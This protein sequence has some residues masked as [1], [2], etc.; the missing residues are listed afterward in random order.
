[1]KRFF[2][3]ILV[4]FPATWLFAELKQAKVERPTAP[5]FVGWVDDEIVVKFD[6]AT[7]A[8][9]DKSALVRGRFGVADFDALAE[10]Y[11]SVNVTEKFP[12]ARAKRYMGR[13]VD[14]RGWT[15]I[16]FSGAVDLDA[17]I[18]D[19][20]A[21]AGVLDAQKIGIHAVYATPNDGNYSS[22]WHLN[23]SNDVDVD[24]PEAWNIQ[25]G[26]S[27]IIVG[28]LDT[29]VRYFHKDLGG[30]NASY[31]TP[32]AV[33]GNMW[34][35]WA[36][37]NGI[38]GV[39]DDGN[40]Y[41][42]DWVGWDWVTGVTGWSGEDVS[43]PDNDPRDFN[44]H[45]THCAGNIAAINNNG[46]ACAAV[47]GGW[48]SGSL[49]PTANGVKVMA[50][51]IGYSA[52]QLI[53]E[54]GYVRM[55]FA[56]S[57]FYYAANNGAK[58]TSCSWGSSNSGG[59]AE[60]VDY[61][62][63]SGGLIFK[64]AG[65]DNTQNADYL[66]NRGDLISVAA[67]DQND[68]KASFSTYGTWVDISA[69]GVGI[70]SLYHNH[71]D[72]QNDYIAS[73]DGTSMATPIAASV[74]A[75]I[76]SQNPSWTAAQVKQRLFDTADDIYSIPGNASFSGKL[77]AGRVNA[78][79]AVNTGG[80]AAP[81]A[82]FIGAPTSGCAP[83]TVNF[84]DQSTGEITSW[85]WNFG[86]GDTSS[87]QNPSTTYASSGSYTVTLTVTGPGGS[88]VETKTNYITVSAPPTAAFTGSPTSG[89]AP[90]TV[91]FTD[92]STGMPTSWSWNFGNGATSTAQNP[93]Y[94]YSTA[95]TYTVSLTVSNA[96]G[97]NATTKTDYITVTQAQQNA[98]HIADITVTKE[99]FSSRVRGKV[100]VKAVDQNGAAASG[101]TVK[102]NWSGATSSSVTFTTGSDGW[103]ENLTKWVKS[104]Q[105]FQFC[106]TSLSKS[107]YTYDASANVA[108][109][110]SSNG[111]IWKAMANV[112]ADNLSALEEQ[113]GEKL[114]VISPNPF[115]PT[116]QLT[117]NLDEAS[118]VRLAIYNVLGEKIK[119][120]YDQR[121]DQ[122]TY[123]II[124]DAHDDLGR[125]VGTGT[126]FYLLNIDNEQVLRGKLLYIK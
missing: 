59:I 126:Y 52:R 44:G 81:N 125:A 22:Q 7:I 95:G 83:L 38:A 99:T 3:I 87:L 17:V 65:N 73:M 71:N 1:M 68:V 78:F 119:T 72:A 89:P 80:P 48:G 10:K 121:L 62:L 120:L 86:N 61:F 45:G 20:L 18:A 49:A 36:E 70:Y 35:N 105:N 74:A 39:D 29:G 9:F 112:A 69:P 12:Q 85:S 5:S 13:E 107:G 46:Y 84:T 40:G 98:V 11:R 42:D 93:S 116:T 110:G 27:S 106:V 54:V 122:G 88:D 37:K 6:R 111:S 79:A 51:R 64:A 8:S 50:L 109:C 47:S 33:D 4:L 14:L 23:Q 118:D 63:A 67:T 41:V 104:S 91:N 57:A 2:A 82:Q 32:T 31:N 117:F 114:L 77:G 108:T 34:I 100:R 96:C 60:A 102:G 19:F 123:S 76:W 101:V 124:W 115:N 26:N 97:S 28:V 66:N 25:T 92:Q 43:T 58:I 55:D 15:G 30:S 53:Y 103:G 21:K 94:T 75:L 24:A 16:K 56:A 90:L 113:L